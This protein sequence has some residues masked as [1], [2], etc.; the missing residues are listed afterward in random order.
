MRPIRLKNVLILSA[1]IA[2]GA[3][4]ARGQSL[5][6]LTTAAPSSDGEGAI[7]M[8]AGNDAFR[9]GAVLRFR[10]SRSSDVGFELGL[11]RLEGRSSIGGGV[12]VKLALLESREDVPLA[13][14]LDLSGGLLDSDERSR[15]E[16][17]L[18]VLASGAFAGSSGRAIEPYLSFVVAA[19]RY[20]Q[21]IEI[22]CD[23]PGAVCPVEDEKTKADGIVRAGVKIAVSKDSQLLAEISFD[24]RTLI[25]GAFNLVF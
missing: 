16:L 19:R 17:A 4:G 25:G 23:P 2:L 22:I 15:F 9:T 24:E 1:A 6:Q 14:A 18:G 8:L 11:D 20:E 7:F 5:A 10:L 13:L 3:S 21:K 12:D